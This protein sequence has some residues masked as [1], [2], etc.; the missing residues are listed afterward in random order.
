M[1]LMVK[2]RRFN[3]SFNYCW[4][5]NYGIFLLSTW[6]STYFLLWKYLVINNHWASYWTLVIASTWIAFMKDCFTSVIHLQQ[7]SNESR[8]LKRSYHGKMMRCENNKA[9]Q[10]SV[11]HFKWR[12]NHSEVD[13]WISH[14]RIL[15]ILKCSWWK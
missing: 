14:L 7:L 9:I 3:F 2:D 10:N 5:H 11:P 1:Y 8:S 12:Q 13:F 4:K 15:Y 6:K